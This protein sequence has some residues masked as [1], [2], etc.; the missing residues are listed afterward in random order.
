[1]ARSGNETATSVVQ[2]APPE[3]A[4]PVLRAQASQRITGLVR[5]LSSRSTVAGILCAAAP[6][7]TPSARLWQASGPTA[8]DGRFEIAAPSGELSVWCDG[9]ASLIAAVRVASGA[10]AELW[11]IRRTTGGGSTGAVLADDPLVPRVLSV[12]ENSAAQRIGVKPGDVIVAIGE[13][14]LDGIGTAVA[15]ELWLQRPTSALTVL[16]GDQLVTLQPPRP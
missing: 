12:G 4:R 2:V 3:I 10:T 5:E 1:M 16:R 11:T 7:A 15:A 6:R 13:Q 14:R 9:G 8:A